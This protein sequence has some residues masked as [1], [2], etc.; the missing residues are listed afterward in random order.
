VKIKIYL[1]ALGRCNLD[2][3]DVQWL[4]RSPGDRRLAYN[5][6]ASLRANS[7]SHFASGSSYF[8]ICECFQLLDC[9]K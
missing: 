5:V 7:G 3:D 6:L 4:L 1:S 9:F 8:E 2:I